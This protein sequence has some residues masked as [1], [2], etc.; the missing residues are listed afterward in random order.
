MKIETAFILCAGFGKRLNPLTLK[1]P[2]PLLKLNNLSL[3][4]NTINLIKSL[5]IRKIKINTFHLEDQIESFVKKKNFNINIEIINDGKDILNTGGGIYNMMKSSSEAESHF[6]VF[7]PDTVW[8]HNYLKTINEM[9]NFYSLNLNN[10][11]LLVVHKKLSFDQNLKGDFNLNKNKLK[12]DSDNEY[13]F[14]GC[15]IINRKIIE[16][17]MWEKLE[18]NFSISETWNNAIKKQS[19]FGFESKN[20]FKHITNLEIYQKLLK[21]N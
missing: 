17:D 13:I 6:L 21:N 20:N 9:I 3:L 10:N 18:N 14:T 11:T 5:N 7:N 19:L 8:D 12:K 4:E 2:K 16:I 1:T 15:Q